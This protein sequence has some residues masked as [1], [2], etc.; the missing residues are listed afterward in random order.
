MQIV[1]HCG[2]SLLGVNELKYSICLVTIMHA[3]GYDSADQ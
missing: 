1:T 3:K 2:I